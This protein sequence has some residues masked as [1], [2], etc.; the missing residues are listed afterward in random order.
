MTNKSNDDTLLK[1]K[2]VKDIF[3]GKISKWNEVNSKSKLGDIRI[4][5]DNNK[6]GNIRYFKD[7]FEI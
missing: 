2:T 6:S 5:F 1:Y 3:L 7:L 4:I